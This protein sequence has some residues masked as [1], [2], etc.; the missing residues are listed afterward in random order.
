VLFLSEIFIYTIKNSFLKSIK[1]SAKMKAVF[2]REA[3]AIMG[4]KL[5]L[6]R[7]I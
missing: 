6:A 7:L 5:W 3:Q 4:R 1:K 2:L